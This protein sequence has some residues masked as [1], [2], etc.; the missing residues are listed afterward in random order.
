MTAPPRDRARAARAI[1]EFLRAMGVAPEGELAGTG[2]RVAEAWDVDLLAGQGVDL[3]ALLGAGAIELGDG[4][5]GIVGLRG[6][7]VASM[8]PHHLL[9]CHGQAI[10]AYAPGRRAAGLGTIAGL[11]HAAARR[12]VLQETLGADVARALVEGLDARGALCRLELVHTCLSARG[13]RQAAARVD[14]IA[15][16]GTFATTGDDRAAAL[17]WLGALAP[18]GDGR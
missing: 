11:V 10:V 14:T 9:P 7:D 5:H 12:L 17:A 15:F 18:R 6:I 8:C 16:A 1:E 2:E 13:E 3:A 4:P